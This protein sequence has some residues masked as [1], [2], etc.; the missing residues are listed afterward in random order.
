MKKVFSKAPLRLALAGGGTDLMP[1]WKEYGGMVLNGTIDQYAYCKI[2]PSDKWIFKS[3]DL[4][5]EEIFDKI[6]NEYVSTKLKLLINTYQY[7]TKK[8]D[9]QTK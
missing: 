3:V 7:L 9:R 2:E 8:Y 6:G 5:I 4:N 1:Y